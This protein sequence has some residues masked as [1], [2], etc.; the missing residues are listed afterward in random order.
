MLKKSLMIK[1]AI[2]LL[3]A[4]VVLVT[5]TLSKKKKGKR[6]TFAPNVSLIPA[7]E[8]FEGDGLPE[9]KDVEYF[10]EEF[11]EES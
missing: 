10:Q 3:I 8:G 1:V 6:V 7:S 5:I 2:A 4:I 11:D 9:Y